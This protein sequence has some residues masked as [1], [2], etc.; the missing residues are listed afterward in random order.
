MTIEEIRCDR[1]AHFVIGPDGGAVQDSTGLYGFCM[2]VDKIG[3]KAVQMRRPEQDVFV[4]PQ[5]V[6]RGS[7]YVKPSFG[8][9]KFEARSQ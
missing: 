7:V 9:N 5:I 8:C 1:C 4:G 3:V 2:Q 6:E